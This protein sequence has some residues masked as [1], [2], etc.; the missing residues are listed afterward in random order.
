M[1]SLGIRRQWVLSHRELRHP[2]FD[3]KEDRRK[4]W[5]PGLSRDGSGEP[6]GHLKTKRGLTGLK[7]QGIGRAAFLLRESVSFP[8]PASRS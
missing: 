7:S 4:A 8:F 3:C 1:L 5:G 2:G 6:R